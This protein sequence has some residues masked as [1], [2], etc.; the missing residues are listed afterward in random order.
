MAEKDKGKIV[1]REEILGLV[2]LVIIFTAIL[3]GR[4]IGDLY[5]SYGELNKMAVNLDFTEEGMSNYLRETIQGRNSTLNVGLAVTLPGFTST[6]AQITQ[7]PDYVRK[8]LISI[9]LSPIVV[10]QPEISDVDLTFQIEGQT[11]LNRTYPFPR[12]KVGYISFVRRNLTLSVEDRATFKKL[13]SDAAA[14]HA[15]EVEVTITGRAKA[16]VLFFEAML[17]FKTTKYPLVLPPTLRLTGS[18]WETMNGSSIRGRIGD[19]TSVG[20]VLT[21]PTRVHSITQNVTC[22]IYLEGDEEP[23]ATITKETTA[24]PGT[25]S[26]YVFNFIPSKPGTYLYTLDSSGIAVPIEASPQL[27]VNP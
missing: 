23:V 9:T 16:N 14:A 7:T 11:V 1:S 3:A 18:G 17:P 5:S 20:I 6:E 4:E 25:E 13:V 21:N 8:W 24:A 22:R 2:Q 15:G 10:T 26:T 27:M 12:E 19:L